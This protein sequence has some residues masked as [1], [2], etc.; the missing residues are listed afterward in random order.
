V[1][2]LR[3]NQIRHGRP[4]DLALLVLIAVLCGLAVPTRAQDTVTVPKSRL[5]ELERKEKELERLRGENTKKV[6]VPRKADSAV[7]PGKSAEAP[8]LPPVLA[9][10]Q[11]PVF[12]YSSPALES[13][14]ALRSDEVVQSEDLANYY[15][16]DHASADRRF[17][18][19]KFALHGEI[20]GFEKPLWK[21]SYRILLKTPV[22]GIRV[23]CDLLPPEKANAV[24][25]I[26]HGD[27][28]V[29][30]Y[31]ETRVPLAR[32]GQKVT[33]QGECKGFSDSV[34]MVY[35]WGLKMAP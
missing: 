24:F 23:I 32:V 2:C 25:T 3:P 33:M 17:L 30:L 19:K 20:V 15:Y 10:P 6:E 31:G 16:A 5:E 13:L 35:A 29:A 26:N 14:P 1:S 27:D 11:E 21:R 22:R 8:A 34:V 12:R 4:F 7:P 28:L 9:P 18:G